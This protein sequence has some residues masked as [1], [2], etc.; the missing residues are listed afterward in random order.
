MKT[1]MTVPV[2]NNQKRSRNFR[3]N[4]DRIASKPIERWM[5]RGVKAPAS[6]AR[7]KP[8]SQEHYNIAHIFDK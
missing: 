4:V 6:S 7:Q 1:I 2:I 8:P 5:L 3:E